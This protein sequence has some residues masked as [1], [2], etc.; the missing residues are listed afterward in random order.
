MKTV[1]EESRSIQHL[2]ASL[3]LKELRTS[4]EVIAP[5]IQTLLD[6]DEAVQ[7]EVAILQKEVLTLVS[8]LRI[9]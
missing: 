3:D 5:M 8:S 4:S 2:F 7:I 1:L 9:I 6:I